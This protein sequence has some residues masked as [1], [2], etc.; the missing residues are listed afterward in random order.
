MREIKFKAWDT[1]LTEWVDY[2]YPYS[3]DIYIAPD[4]VVWARSSDE[5]GGHF[6]PADEKRY[7]IVWYIGLKD[8][9]GKEIYE[10][11]IV[12]SGFMGQATVVYWHQNTACWRRTGFTGMTKSDM[13]LMGEVIGN[14]YE[15]PELLL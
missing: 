13:A 1:W 5:G 14:I 8:K 12:R 10:W 4:G 2:S 15:N 3:D 9:N 6:M 11:D 7:E